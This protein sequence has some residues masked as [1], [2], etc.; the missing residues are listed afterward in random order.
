MTIKAAS[1]MTDK[2][3]TVALSQ[4]EKTRKQLA[5]EAQRTLKRLNALHISA[6]G[7]PFPR[8]LAEAEDVSFDQVFEQNYGYYKD[9]ANYEY[10]IIRNI[11]RYVMIFAI[12]VASVGISIFTLSS[13]PW[14]IFGFALVIVGCLAFCCPHLALRLAQSTV[15]TRAEFARN[16][17][18]R[19]EQSLDVRQ[20]E[21][22]KVYGHYRGQLQTLHHQMRETETL[23]QQYQERIE[24]QLKVG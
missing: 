6:Y 10:A 3:L 22:E 2:Q 13:P 21:I 18:S 11:A 24:D 15:R 12:V 16:M 17:V 14:S 9:K 1:T 23:S 5:K 20:A 19:H 8:N 7:C 4:G